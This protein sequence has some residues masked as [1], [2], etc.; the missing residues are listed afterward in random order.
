MHS[1]LFLV[2][3]SP[4]TRQADHIDWFVDLSDKLIGD[5]VLPKIAKAKLLGEDVASVPEIEEVGQVYQAMTLRARF[6]M[7]EGPLLVKSKEPMTLEQ[8]ETY[9]RSLAPDELTRFIK[10]TRV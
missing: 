3:V 9:V 4:S 5:K 6:A 1:Y 2:V 7:A 10:R 8:V